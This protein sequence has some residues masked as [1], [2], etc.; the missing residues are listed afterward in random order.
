[1]D[2]LAGLLRIEI[3]VLLGALALVVL[4]Q[5][6]TG[7]IS[8]HGILS[9][10]DGN[11]SPERAQMLIVTLIA[12]FSYLAQVMDHTDRLPAVPEWMLVAFVGSQIIY[13]WGKSQKE[14]G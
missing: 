11:A 12:A 6:L 3:A 1:V 13:L 2:L 5:M 10:Q 14:G 9:D 8:F 4:F 7:W